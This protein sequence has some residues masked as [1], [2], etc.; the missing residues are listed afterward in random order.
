MIDKSSQNLW[1]VAKSLS[2][3]GYQVIFDANGVATLKL[4]YSHLAPAGRLVI[5]GR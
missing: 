5:Y 3:Q 1:E 4:S 2:P